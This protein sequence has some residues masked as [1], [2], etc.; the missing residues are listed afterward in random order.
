LSRIKAR[1][2]PGEEH[3]RKKKL[4]TEGSK[5]AKLSL[6]PDVPI[7]GQPK[8]VE[9]ELSEQINLLGVAMASMVTASRV[10]I[11]TGLDACCNAID[12]LLL[13][14]GDIEEDK[15]DLVL[16]QIKQGVK[17]NYF[18]M[19]KNLKAQQSVQ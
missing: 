17:T 14:L 5:M 12:R 16:E 8:E 10:K 2:L 4:P 13:L 7:V 6:T 1:G 15:L 11:E 3:W 9:A 19:K 18:V